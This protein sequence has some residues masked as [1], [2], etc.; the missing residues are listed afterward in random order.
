M[1]PVRVID[2][3]A[4]PL[5]LSNVD[6]DVIIR[7]EKLAQCPREELGRW[8]LEPLRMRADGSENADCL[9]NQPGWREA[10]I[11]VA[12]PNFGC[13][14]SREHAVWALQGLGIDCVIAPSF[15]DIFRNNC[16]QNG[17]LPVQL[18]PDQAQW[19]L[20]ALEQRRQQGE[21]VR[22]MVDLEAQVVRWPGQRELPFAVEPRRRHAL[23]EGLDEVGLTRQLLP[24]IDAWQARDRKARPWIWPTAQL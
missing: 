7:I 16:F 6:T 19:L 23:L 4:A 9:L 21:A 17:L 8:A 24:Q 13:G 12:G 14:S 5:P 18:P 3:V 20:D 10:R 1:K 11:L 15:G 2:G 22:L